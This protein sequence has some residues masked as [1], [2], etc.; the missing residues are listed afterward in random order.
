MMD[1]DHLA[2]WECVLLFG[3]KWIERNLSKCGM[4]DYNG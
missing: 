1:W 3:C 2:I 4:M